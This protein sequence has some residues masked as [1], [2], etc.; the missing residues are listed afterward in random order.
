MKM[1]SVRCLSEIC[2]NLYH[3][4]TIGGYIIC[5]KLSPGTYSNPIYQWVHGVAV[6]IE[7]QPGNLNL[8]A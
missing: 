3:F 7:T 8:A 6:S 4:T 1:F 5:W 2:I